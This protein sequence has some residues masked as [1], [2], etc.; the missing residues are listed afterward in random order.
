MTGDPR[1][2]DSSHTNYRLPRNSPAI[3]AG[4]NSAISG[5]VTDLDGNPRIVDGDSNGRLIVDMGA[6][7]LP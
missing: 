3:D 5:L 6:Y 2:V 7:E 4:D 1:F